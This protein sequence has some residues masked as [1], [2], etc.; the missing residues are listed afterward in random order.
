MPRSRL[1]VNRFQLP[2]SIE[3]SALLKPISNYRNPVVR[4]VQLTGIGSRTATLPFRVVGLYNG[5]GNG[6]D[7]TTDYNWVIVAANVAGA[8]STGI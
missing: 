3:S 7:A 5:V 2:E 1:R 6:S 4:L 8:G